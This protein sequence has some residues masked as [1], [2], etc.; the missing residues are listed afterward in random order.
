MLV[1]K[2]LGNIWREN[3]FHHNDTP[4]FLYPYPQYF[5]LSVIM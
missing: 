5:A 3:I 4:K 1:A 2:E